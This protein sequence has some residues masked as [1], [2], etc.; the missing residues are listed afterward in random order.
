MSSDDAPASGLMQISH[1]LE[2]CC[3]GAG[4]GPSGQG[5]GGG[6]RAEAEVQLMEGQASWLVHIVGAV[7]RGRNNSSSGE[8]QVGLLCVCLVVEG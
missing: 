7:V 2:H 3:A 5:P 6:P 4:A 1:D 8:S